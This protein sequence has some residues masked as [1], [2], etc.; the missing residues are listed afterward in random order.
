MEEIGTGG[1]DRDWWRRSG[2][3]EEIG[4]GGGD[5]DWLSNGCC[6]DGDMLATSGRSQGSNAAAA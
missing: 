3:M 1:G 5:R 4:T 6:R 2:L